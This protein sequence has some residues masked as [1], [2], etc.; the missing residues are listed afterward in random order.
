MQFSFESDNIFLGKTGDYLLTQ[1]ANEH[2]KDACKALVITYYSSH[3]IR[4]TIATEALRAGMDEVTA[5]HTFGWKDRATMQTYI[6]P[7]RTKTEQQ[8]ILTMF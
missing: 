2:L 5:M 7:V 3:K 1:E 6:R 4:A 8:K